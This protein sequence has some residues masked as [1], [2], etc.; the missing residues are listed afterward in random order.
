MYL[1]LC[2]TVSVKQDFFKALWPFSTLNLSSVVVST[3][4]SYCAMEKGI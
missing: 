2:G 4:S 1:L 3:P